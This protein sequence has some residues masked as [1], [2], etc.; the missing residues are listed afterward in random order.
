LPFT[1]EEWG[2]RLLFA[3]PPGLGDRFSLLFDALFIRVV[4][5]II[6]LLLL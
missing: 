5:K 3:A 2:G 6:E 4:L 1:L